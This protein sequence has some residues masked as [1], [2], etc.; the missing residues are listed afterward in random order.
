MGI[1]NKNGYKEWVKQ[2]AYDI[3]M[4]KETLSHLDKKITETI[5]KQ[6]YNEKRIDEIESDIKKKSIQYFSII[7]TSILSFI[8][9]L[10]LYIISRI[11]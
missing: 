1:E 9:G 7:I 4:I 11:K 8:I 5:I 10:T 6:Q 2:I 3:S